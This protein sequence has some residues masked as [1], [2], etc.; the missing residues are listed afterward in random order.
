MTDTL[1]RALAGAALTVAPLQLLVGGWSGAVVYLVSVSSNDT[2]RVEHCILKLDRKGKSAKSDEVTRH[3][4]VMRKSTAAF[5]RDHIAELV[6]DRVE[7]EGAIAIFYRIAGQSLLKYRPL[8][9]Y[10]QQS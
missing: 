9:S 3:N 6:F 10:G 5:A 2:R 4:T 7:H 1:E 8:S